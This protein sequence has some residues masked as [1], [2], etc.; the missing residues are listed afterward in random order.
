MCAVGNACFRFYRFNENH[1]KPYGFQRGDANHFL[2]HAW[3]KSD[4][5]LAGTTDGRL[6]LFERGDYRQDIVIKN[7]KNE[8][9][10]A[11]A[12]K[13]RNIAKVREQKVG[14]D[15]AIHTK[16]DHNRPPS[17]Y[18]G[19]EITAIVTYSKGF[20]VAYGVGNVIVF[21]EQA[22]YTSSEDHYKQMYVIRIPSDTS[23]S[24][25][26]IVKTLTISPNEEVI[27]ASTFNCNI[28][29]FQLS[30]AEIKVVILYDGFS[31]TICYM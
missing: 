17:V 26:R 22:V 25:D 1:L 12:E 15:A 6:M 21:E 30:S 4:K 20:V 18:V 16:E 29:M 28:Y 9:T 7:V 10:G 3:Y 8:I 19:K 24:E 11:L 14:S 31:A 23:E 13:G 27:V 2:C 5:V